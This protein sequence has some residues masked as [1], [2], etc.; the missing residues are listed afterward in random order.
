[1]RDSEFDEKIMGPVK[2]IPEGWNVWDRI[3]INETKTCGQLIDYLK[4]KYNIDVDMLTADGVTIITTFAGKNIE[5][6]NTKIE[7]AYEK[8]ANKKIGTKKKY[9]N[10]QVVGSIEET[11]I[12][13]KKVKNASVFIPPIKYMLNK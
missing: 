1:M 9:L 7:D 12:D 5:K 4:E 8:N 10:I 13:K 2:A 11:E 6:W 3:D